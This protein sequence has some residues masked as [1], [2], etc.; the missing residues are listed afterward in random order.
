MKR[1]IDYKYIVVA[2]MVLISSC[3]L[4]QINPNAPSEKE[5][6]TTREGIIAL[7]IGLRQFYSTTGLSNTMLTP[8]VTAREVKGI[9]TFTNTLEVEA[10]GTTLPT[11]NGNILA[12]WSSMQREMS[13][14][15]DIIN[16][17]PKVPTIEPALLS[18]I[19]G[20]AYL[21][22]AM[23]LSELAMAFEHTNINTSATS[24]VAFVPRAQAFAEAI[25]LLDLGIA[26]ITA[27]PPSSG[28]TTL[29]SGPDFDLKNSLYAYQA[30]ISLM[31]GN[32]QKALDNANL[33]DLGKASR[34]TYS[35]LSPNPLYTLY[36]VTISYR[37]R[38]NFGLPT[39]LYEAGDQRYNFYFT[40]PKAVVNGDAV[41]S[42][43]GFA[44][45]QTT[46]IPVYL[47][48][49][50][51]L[52]KAEAILRLRGSI[53]DALGF[54]N[55]VRTQVSGDLFG[56]NAGLGTYVGALSYDALLLEVYKQRCAEL[57][58]SGLKWEDTRRFDRPAPPASTAERNRIFYP[59]PDQERINNPNT[60]SD[61]GI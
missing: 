52:I 27:S 11:A 38:E 5:T 8:C 61:P 43:A 34:F 55:D 37:P 60:P 32:N 15:E 35:T 13:M 57:Y 23:A 54:I 29:V 46:S 58:L 31:A 10:G 47:T 2:V 56:V 1:K 21:F 39:G 44:S 26:A 20:Q 41:V 49:E 17:A 25:R 3:K 33:V 59:Y 12:L 19:M 30:R 51:K 9:A 48:D 45:S 18:G 6:L 14:C 36:N 50:I 4:D 53:P 7:S 22:K 28:F 24:P 42:M 40:A 16:N